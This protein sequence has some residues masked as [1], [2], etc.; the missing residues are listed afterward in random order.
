MTTKVLKIESWRQKSFWLLAGLAAVTLA[1]YIYLINN[2]VFNLA[3]RASITSEREQLTLDLGQLEARYL[4]MVDSIT[5]ER[6]YALGFEDAGANGSFA[7]V[8]IPVLAY[9]D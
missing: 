8:A 6:A 7:A 1:F 4:A 3:T 9:G 2:I 5:I